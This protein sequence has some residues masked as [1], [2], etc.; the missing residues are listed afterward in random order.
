MWYTTGYQMT[1]KPDGT[2]EIVKDT[3]GEMVESGKRATTTSYANAKE[4]IVGRM[5]PKVYGGFNTR[6]EFFGVDVTADFAY[7]LGGKVYDNQYAQF[8]SPAKSG[9][10]GF[11]IHEDALKSWS[12]SNQ[13]S[14]LPRYQFGDENTG[15]LSSRFLTKASYLSLQNLSVGYTLPA[16]LT[17]KAKIE[18]ARV[19]MNA[20]NVWLWS[21]RRGLD[22]R[23]AM[24]DSG[25]GYS[26]ASYYSTVRT[27][28]AGVNVTF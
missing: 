21:A 26:N 10:I 9:K 22:P 13:G 7:Q 23:T 25:Y 17:R 1:T 2:R 6:L 5:L 18:K 27:I 3:N 4:Y 16:N 19:Y 15:S 20:S 12:A 24:I 8:M 14:N 28:S 11:N